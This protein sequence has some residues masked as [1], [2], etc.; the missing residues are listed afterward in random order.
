MR[1]FVAVWVKVPAGLREWIAGA[2]ALS[3][4]VRWVREDNAHLTPRFLGEAPA[5]AVP[6]LQASLR[7]VRCRKLDYSLVGLGCFPSPSRPQ[8][9]WAGVR[10]DSGGL[11]TLAEA[12]EEATLGNGVAAEKRSFRPHL[13]LAR[14]RNTSELLGVMACACRERMTES[15][16]GRASA[17]SFA[18]VESRPGSHYTEI[19]NW[20]LE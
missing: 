7:S 2:R 14:A 10:D 9:L 16:W 18:L 4:G 11:A 1:L 17:D 20:R 6:G 15:R 8:V 3:P 12:V 5:S 19:G 13:T